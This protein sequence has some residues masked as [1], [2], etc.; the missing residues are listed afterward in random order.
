MLAPIVG[1]ITQA[2][3]NSTRLP[4]KVMKEVLSKPLLGHQLERLRRSKLASRVI[5]AT[6]ENPGDEPIVSLCAK[7]DTP[8]YRGS[9]DDVLARF[10]GAAAA[11]GLE[12]IARVTSDCPLIDPAV[13][14]SVLA[15]YMKAP[16]LYDYVSNTRQRT[17]PRGMD[18]EVFS[19]KSLQEA[20]AEAREPSER[21]H[22]TPFFYHRPE[23][24]R[25]GDVLRATDESRHRW[26]VDTE[27]DYSL[28]RAIIE[29]LAP[30]KP[31]Y[32]LD[33][34]LELLRR[35]PELANLN[36]HVAQKQP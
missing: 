9:E 23:R 3:M 18:V 31:E 13:V 19:A 27:E 4:G 8:C 21:E 32:T 7:L 16:G 33:D 20:N 15:A 24:F 34:C 35:R 2:R 17:F 10:A 28:A 6:T 1:I 11:H 12:V 29:S 5:V 25:L 26:T 14:D 30:T 22:V 36:A